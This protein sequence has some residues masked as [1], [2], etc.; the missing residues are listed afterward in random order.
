MVGLNRLRNKLP[1]PDHS[2]ADF[3]TAQKD[4]ANNFRAGMPNM[5]TQMH[6]QLEADTGRQ[7][8]NDVRD[9]HASNSSRGLLYGGINAGGEGKLR[10][11]ASANV[12]SGK[13][14]INKGLIDQASQFDQD[15]ISTGLS[16]Q[17]SQQ[18]I[19]NSIYQN[20][21]ARQ[22]GQDQIAG[23]AVQAGTMIALMSDMNLKEDIGFASKE[24]EQILNN[25]VEV[26]YKYK[27]E[28]FGSGEQVGILAQHLEGTPASGVV[29]NTEHG[30]GV[31]VSKAVGLALAGLA[32]INRRLNALE[33]K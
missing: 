13:M 28:N 14:N 31:D 16:I 18:Q 25:L 20:A 2:I 4:Y 1:A 30:R 21:M 10:A 12:A 8:N 19:Q 7:L 27:D 33:G 24:I 22:M 3:Q 11:S 26:K 32:N 15:A 23:S 17:Q 5:A 6:T 9:L 29:V